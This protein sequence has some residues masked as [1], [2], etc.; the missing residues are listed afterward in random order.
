MNK[1]VDLTIF[2]HSTGESGSFS[3][4]VRV[5]MDNHSKSRSLLNLAS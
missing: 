5:G 1:I 4:A 2:N 3:H